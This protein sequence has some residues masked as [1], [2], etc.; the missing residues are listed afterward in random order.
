M[1]SE[2]GRE[3]AI[4]AFMYPETLCHKRRIGR[5]QSD[6]QLELVAACGIRVDEYNRCRSR[7]KFL[8]RL[9]QFSSF[10]GWANRSVLEGKLS[11]QPP[12]KN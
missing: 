7:G 9:K 3:Q 4:R 1:S 8:W 5:S 10:P 2:L 6:D 12:H 11:F